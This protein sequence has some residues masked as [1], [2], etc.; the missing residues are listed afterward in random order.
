MIDQMIYLE[1]MYTRLL[2]CIE[3][4]GLQHYNELIQLL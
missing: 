4:H 1:Q 2:N 3:N